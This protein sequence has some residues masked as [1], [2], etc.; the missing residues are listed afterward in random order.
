MQEDIRALA[1]AL[2]WVMTLDVVI[3]AP[4]DLGESVDGHRANYPITGGQFVGVG[5]Q[6]EVLPGGADFYCLRPD[7]VGDLDATYSLRTD[8]G[9]LINIRNRGFLVLG[10]EGRLLEAKGV[11]PLPEHLYRCSCSP[12][13]QVARGALGWLAEAAFIGQVTYPSDTR[14]VIRIYRLA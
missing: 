8:Q 13:F 5:I 3:G 1:P 7:G 6:G 2:E 11:W 14:V 4:Q 10:E 12:S 9:E